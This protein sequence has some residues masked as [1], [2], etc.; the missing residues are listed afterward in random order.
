MTEINPEIRRQE[1][2]QSLMDKAQE[3][4]QQAERLRKQERQA[5]IIEILEKMKAYS[6]KLH[7]LEPARRQAMRLVGEPVYR[8]PATRKTW[9]GMGRMPGW[10]KSAIENGT[11]IESFRI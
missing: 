2:Y 1:S 4:M 10:L 6:I 3:L 9:T 11:P 8:D 5:A 7:D